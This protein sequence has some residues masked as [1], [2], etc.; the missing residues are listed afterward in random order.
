MKAE[1]SVNGLCGHSTLENFN[2]LLSPIE[3]KIEETEIFVS[4][5]SN[6]VYQISDVPQNEHESQCKA[7]FMSGLFLC[8]IFN[9]KLT[10]FDV[11]RDHRQLI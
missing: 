10:A 8:I 4:S 5:W 11:H 3:A 1:N 2:D 7:I 9:M 6:S